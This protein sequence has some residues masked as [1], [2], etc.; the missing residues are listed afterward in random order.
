ME[1]R[2]SLRGSSGETRWAR[3]AASWIVSQRPSTC[4]MQ[5]AGP[6]QSL[7]QVSALRP[8][9]PSA[10]RRPGSS[11]ASRVC[12]GGGTAGPL[13]MASSVRLPSVSPSPFLPLPSR[14]LQLLPCLVV[15]LS[16]AGFQTPWP[17]L[18]RREGC[19]GTT[20]SAGLAPATLPTVLGVGQV[21]QAGQGGLWAPPCP[22][23]RAGH[24]IPVWAGQTPPGA[25]VPLRAWAWARA[26]PRLS[27]G[28]SR[29]PAPGGCHAPR[30]T[31]RLVPGLRLGPDPALL[32]RGH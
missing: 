4:G 17:G 2:P 28:L 16:P 18:G 21:G 23:G 14:F 5:G 31:R 15:A 20:P 26:S 24:P 30:G 3:L 7:A 10:E 1:W 9:H 6:G 27:A 12:W 22:R 19:P 13:E 29:G 32:P 25:A 11:R 8:Q